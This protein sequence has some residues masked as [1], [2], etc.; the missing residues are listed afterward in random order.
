MATDTGPNVSKHGATTARI[1][2]RCAI[3]AC[4]LLFAAT[5]GAAER[6]WLLQ[7]VKTQSGANV[8]GSVSYDDAANHVTSWILQIEGGNGMPPFTYVPANATHWSGI[9]GSPP[10]LS[11]Y[12]YG[13]SGLTEGEH[14]LHLSLAGAL[15]GTSASVALLTFDPVSKG[16]FSAECR[17][18][19]GCRAIV[20]GAFA[21][22]PGPPAV[23]FVDVVEF[24][25]AAFNH[26][27]M[28]ANPAEIAKLDSGYFTGWAR[29]G[30]A[31]K[32]YA[33]GSRPGL[34]TNPVCRYY[35]L[36][37]AGL[38]SHFYS[39]SAVECYQVYKRFG[40][41]WLMES[42]DVFQIDLPDA[43][44][45]TCLPGTIA[46]YRVFNNRADANHRYMTS[47]AVRAQME[48]AGWIREGYG[49]S[50]T[51]MCAVAP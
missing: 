31:F 4:A 49:P 51:I 26:Y 14:F 10:F 2:R 23:G 18:E 19:F 42:D 33:V 37:S 36:P 35:G 38:D 1:L 22:V 40:Y 32:A 9:E 7:G 34:A 41:A 15:D 16:Y 29:T 13:V 17:G 39:A 12:F 3:A 20:S 45:G 28:T 43:T 6:H 44:T 46:I 30:Y 27:F 24:H 48:G 11:L 25:H 21:L 47:L 8:S 50:A 5:A